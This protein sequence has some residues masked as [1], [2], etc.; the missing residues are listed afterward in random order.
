MADRPDGLVYEPEF[1]GADDER[2][3]L[4]LFDGL[5]FDR[6]EM[7][8]QVARR[9]ALHFG[10]AYDYDNPGRSEAGEP[11]PGWLLPLR[12][13]AA[14]LAGVAPEELVEALVQDYPPQATI[15]WHRDAP[16]FGKVIGISLGA[17]CRMRFRRPSGDRRDVFE[18]VLEPRSAYVLAGSSRWQWQHS[19]PAVKEERYSI[20]FRTLRPRSGVE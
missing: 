5:E 9:T 8:G 6:I 12:K 4:D 16:M 10:V 15:G 18:L 20:T 1:L 17:A 13:R 3:L 2:A 11:F 7:R 14:A 19:I